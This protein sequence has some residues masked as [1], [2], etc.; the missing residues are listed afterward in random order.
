MM[1]SK[2]CKT[3]ALM[4]PTLRAEWRKHASPTMV[5]WLAS[6]ESRRRI[7][8]ERDRP[9]RDLRDALEQ[10]EDQGV[11]AA[12]EK[13]LH[14]SEA[15]VWHAVPVASQDDR[16]RRFLAGLASSYPRAG[17]VQWFNP[18]RDTDWEAWISSGCTDG[19]CFRCCP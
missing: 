9:V 3:G 17:K 8:A 11:K 12:I 14:L 15:A 5:G 13:D 10:V 2:D 6:M 19:T 16:Q 1:A 4:T 18:V 7:R